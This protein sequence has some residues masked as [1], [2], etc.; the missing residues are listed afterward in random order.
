MKLRL[1][2]LREAN[3]LSQQALAEKAGLVQSTITN[4]EL[5]KHNPRWQTIHMLAK[6]LKVKPQDLVAREE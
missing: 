4:L 6:A 5:G 1:R 3:F 2:E